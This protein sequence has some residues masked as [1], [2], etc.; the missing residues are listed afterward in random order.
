MKKMILQRDTTPATN[1][2]LHRMELRITNLFEKMSEHLDARFEKLHDDVDARFKELT[3]EMDR[4]FDK[5]HHDIDLVLAN[6]AQL[7]EKFSPLLGES[8]RPLGRLKPIRAL[9]RT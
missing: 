3:V 6:V 8:V 1:D 4:R 5:V 7:D 2:D 9:R